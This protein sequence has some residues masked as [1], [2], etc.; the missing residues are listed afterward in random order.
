MALLSASSFSGSSSTQPAAAAVVGSGERL[1]KFAG[2]RQS[3]KTSRFSW[4]PVQRPGWVG[5]SWVELGWVRGEEGGGTPLTSIFKASALWAD[6]FYKSICPSVCL[7]VCPSVRVF[8][9]EVPFN[10][11]FA[12]TSRS[13]MSNIFRDSE[14]LGK[15]NGKKWYHI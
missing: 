1:V 2:P 13:R 15:R 7:C 14:F 6:A 11:H 5:L 10:G 4:E 8:T 9:F 3:S 12:P